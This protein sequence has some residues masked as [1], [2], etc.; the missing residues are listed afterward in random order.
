MKILVIPAGSIYSGLAWLE[1]HFGRSLY[2]FK[3]NVGIQPMGTSWLEEEVGP[4][5]TAKITNKT[6]DKKNL[7]CLS[8]DK[9]R[10]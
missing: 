9:Y 2:H 3:A 6:C 1:S 8:N 4:E 7:I 10:Q 5:M